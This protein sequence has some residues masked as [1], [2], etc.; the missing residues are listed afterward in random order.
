MVIV[1]VRED[2]PVLLATEYE[3]V[4]LPEPL[5]PA[6][7]VMNVALLTADHVQPAPAVTLTLPVPPAAA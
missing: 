1:P 2:V 6:V 4:P 5:E 3:T 7:I